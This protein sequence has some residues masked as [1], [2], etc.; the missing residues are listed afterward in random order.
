MPAIRTIRHGHRLLRASDW[1]ASGL[2][3]VLLPPLIGAVAAKLL[4]QGPPADGPPGLIDLVVGVLAL[5]VFAP[6]V[7]IVVT[8]PAVL[9]GMGLLRIG[10]GGWLVAAALPAALAAVLILI[11]AVCGSGYTVDSYLPQMAFFS[12]SA[13]FHGAILWGTLRLRRPEALRAR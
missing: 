7:T 13:A 4:D 6:L 11:F 3:V 9:L 5:Q 8:V 10:Y 1:A 12:S 2:A